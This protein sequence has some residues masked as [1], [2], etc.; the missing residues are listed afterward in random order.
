MK[1]AHAAIAAATSSASGQCG[2]AVARKIA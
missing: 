1:S 2:R